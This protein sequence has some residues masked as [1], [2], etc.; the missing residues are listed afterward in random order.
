MDRFKSSAE[1]KGMAK[2]QLFGN[3]GTAIGASLLAGIIMMGM[4][5]FIQIFSALTAGGTLSVPQLIIQFLILFITSLFSG[6]LA[7]GEA[8]F[9]L[10]V[11]CRQPVAISDIFYGFRVYP[12]KA[13]LLQLAFS[14]VSNIR[15]LPMMIFYILCLTHPQNTVYMLFLSICFVI[16]TI[17]V[18]VLNLMFSQ[19]FYLLQD[20]PQY[21]AKELLQMSCQIMKGHK[22]RLF[23]IS[24]SF[25]PLYL[26]GIFSCCV[27]FL[28]IIPYVNAVKANFYMDLMR[29]RSR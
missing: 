21:S 6:L 2:E 13:L 28:W 16:G 12:D 5:F 19:S 27:A 7:S 15:Q 20:F 24:I 3:Y 8:F 23:Y 29:G 26:L 1:L 17:L 22:G 14:L 4:L 11:T 10:K 9:Y 25:V 18:T